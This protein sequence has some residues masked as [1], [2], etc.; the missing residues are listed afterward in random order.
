MK[1]YTI[2]KLNNDGAAL[3]MAIL[4]I[5]FVSILTTILL[6]L[7]NMNYQ[8]KSTDFK[9]KDAFYYS[10]IPL[11]TVRTR[12]VMDV[13]EA[14]TTSYDTMVLNYAN[15]DGAVRASEFQDSFYDSVIDAWKT[16]CQNEATA[17][18]WKYGFEQLFASAASPISSADIHVLKST[19]WSDSG[20][21]D[22]DCAKPYHLILDNNYAD[23]S[24]TANSRLRIVNDTDEAGNP[25]NKLQLFGVK[26]VFTKNEF[27]SIIETNYNIVPPG[28]ELDVDG[29][30]DDTPAEAI[31]RKDVN[32]ETCVTYIGYKKQ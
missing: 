14:V 30:I 22:T 16:R 12:L 11:E 3:V 21:G 24:G 25:V 17:W 4:V 28:V 27:T 13:A 7:A 2:K 1:K 5:A 26:L 10:E 29:F 8:M 18:D 6:Y 19:D 9:T 20:C 32:F 15:M 31:K 23:E